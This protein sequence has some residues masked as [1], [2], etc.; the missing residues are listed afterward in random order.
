[1]HH[2]FVGL[3]VVAV[4]IAVGVAAMPRRTRTLDGEEVLER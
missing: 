2:V 1:M 3:V 4:V